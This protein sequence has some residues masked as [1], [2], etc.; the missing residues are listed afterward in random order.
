MG[1]GPGDIFAS[2]KRAAASSRT[3]KDSAK[4]PPGH[5]VT[6][7]L[8]DLGGL[9]ICRKPSE[10][11]GGH[12]R[13]ETWYQ[14]DAGEVL[15]EHAAPCSRHAARR[16]RLTPGRIDDAF[17]RLPLPPSPLHIQPS[18]GRTRVNFDTIFFT[19]AKPFTRGVR[20]LGHRIAFSISPA[21]YTW[22]WGD[23]QVARTTWPGRA[24]A[25]AVPISD[26]I[27]HRYE[28]VA[29]FRPRLDTTYAATYSVDGGPP[30]SVPGTVTIQGAP[31]TLEVHAYRPVLVK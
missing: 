21:T 12:I 24:Y 6:R 23:G 17:R 13:M 14:T 1:T 4:L 19:T 11:P 25:P 31:A 29:T 8:C 5:W 9:S 7:P 2:G 27:T 30:R 18:G 15:Y 16:P 20:L 10:C 3:S 22:T 28:S 26:D